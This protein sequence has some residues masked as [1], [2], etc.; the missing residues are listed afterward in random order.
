M[1]VPDDIINLILSFVDSCSYCNAPVFY[2]DSKK[3]DNNFTVCSRCN[4]IFH[5]CKECKKSYKDSLFCRM[6]GS[7]CN[8]LCKECL[9]KSPLFV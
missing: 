6:C 5:F 4:N 1:E 9:S 2:E 3:D 8:F 7:I